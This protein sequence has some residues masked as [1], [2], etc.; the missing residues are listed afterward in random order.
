[1]NQVVGHAIGLAN[2]VA[3]TRKGR[4]ARLLALTSEKNASHP[5]R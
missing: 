3:L 2:D 4:P 1:M 5:L